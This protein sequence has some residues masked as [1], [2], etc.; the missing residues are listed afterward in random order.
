MRCLLLLIVFFT[1]TFAYSADI[2]SIEVDTRGIWNCEDKLVKSDGKTFFDEGTPI[3]GAC[4]S[5]HDK[6]IYD[7]FSHS[8]AEVKDGLL[9]GKKVIYYKDGSK[10]LDTSYVDGIIDSI[11]V[12]NVD[13]SLRYSETQLYGQMSEKLQSRAY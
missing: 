6:Q 9:S 4:V 8:Y 5:T 2:V 11:H 13:G 3:T 12:Y 1:A 10:F 7:K